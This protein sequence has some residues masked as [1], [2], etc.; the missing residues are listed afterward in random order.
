LIELFLAM[1]LKA[2]VGGKLV[3]FKLSPELARAHRAN[4]DK[5]MTDKQAVSFVEKKRRART[6]KLIIHR[7]KSILLLLALSITPLLAEENKDNSPPPGF[8]ALF[9]G[10]D[11]TNWKGWV[12]APP[13]RLAMSKEELAAAQKIADEQMRAHWHVENGVIVFDG[14]GKS[15]CTTK[16]YGDFELWVDWKI[17]ADG[18]SGIYL[19]GCPQV[20][21]WDP[22]SKKGARD[23]SVGSGGLH[24]N[25]KHSN[26]PLKRA[27]KPIGEWN[28]F[29]IKMTG[30]KVTVRL[31]G[32]LVVDNE[33]FENSAEKGKPLYATGP[34]ELQNHGDKLF[35][36]NI[37]IRES[38]KR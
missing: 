26:V 29:E 15:L 20:Q 33:T 34:I 32:E 38:V 24:N 13:K 2:I 22:A 35:F 23:H 18:D 19:R 9:N 4:A 17:P 31:N 5:T 16:D 3:S 37:Y 36:K 11:L 27:D 6:S 7:M 14:K 25:A 12:G 1:R 8:V 30:D 28:H 21:I 10:K